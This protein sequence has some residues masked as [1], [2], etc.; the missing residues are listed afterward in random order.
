[1]KNTNMLLI[2]FNYRKNDSEWMA[3]DGAASVTVFIV[4]FSNLLD[5][6]WPSYLMKVENLQFA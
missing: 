4:I 3:D 5:I 6:S 1:M 2:S